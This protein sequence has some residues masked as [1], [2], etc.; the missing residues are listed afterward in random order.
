[1]TVGPIEV[2]VRGY[3]AS[4]HP[5]RV[6]ES[7]PSLT[8]DQ[9]LAEI[10]KL[11]PQ[12]IREKGLLTNLNGSEL[13]GDYD[14]VHT[15]LAPSLASLN[16]QFSTALLTL[17]QSLSPPSP[18]PLTSPPAATVPVDTGKTE[19]ADDAAAD[20]P[21]GETETDGGGNAETPPSG[22]GD[23]GGSFWTNWGT[24]TLGV[25]GA[26][27]WIGSFFASEEG[28]KGKSIFAGIGALL[29]GGAAVSQWP[30]ISGLFG[31][32]TP[33]AATDK[34]TEGEDP[35]PEPEVT[36]AGGAEEGK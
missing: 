33:A 28:S 12:Q 6:Q 24:L 35:K 27:A 25:V 8:P 15:D 36:P 14:K 29:V 13:G 22:D 21:A 34:A 17:R 1:M 20:K 3:K 11:T 16:G 5:S 9:A 23:G 7:Y 2:N 18:A 10:P 4:L 31:K 26:L 32:T 30:N 19:G